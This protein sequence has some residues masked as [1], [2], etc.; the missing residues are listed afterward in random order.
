[1]VFTIY[2]KDGSLA[3]LTNAEGSYALFTPDGEIQFMKSSTSGAI[4][5]DV[6]N[7]TAT[8]HL[9]PNDTIRIYGTFRHQL[10]ILDLNDYSEIVA[11]GK[12][13]IKR[14]FVRMFRL[15]SLVAFLQGG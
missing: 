6:P 1:M 14:S 10:H 3:A 9:T 8:V 7:S 11:T 12:V 15:D 4:T 2:N 5:F 13:N